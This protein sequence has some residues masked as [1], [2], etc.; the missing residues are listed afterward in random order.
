MK[1]NELL[2]GVPL[3]DAAAD[4]ETEITGVS[5]DSRQTRPGDLF[6]AMTGYA[7]DG[8][9]YI[10]AALE[11]GA[12]AVLCETPPE[13]AGLPWVRTADSRLADHA[14]VIRYSTRR[15]NDYTG[16]AHNTITEI[17]LT[18]RDKEDRAMVGMIIREPPDSG[19]VRAGQSLGGGYAPPE[20][21]W[22][23]IKFLF[24]TP[25]PTDDLK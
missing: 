9:K 3:L 7:T 22:R 20:D 23:N 4:L 10:P 2:S 8:H 19:T 12:A 21:I 17:Y 14:I 15:R 18:G 1:L 11:K 13:G 16:P 5:Y 24:E 6:V 25:E